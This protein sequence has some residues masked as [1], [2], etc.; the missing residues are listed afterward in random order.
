MIAATRSIVSCLILALCLLAAL[1]G[2]A[3][4]QSPE[5][6]AHRD[7]SALHFY[8]ITVDVGG[9]VWDNF[10]HSALRVVDELND[11]DVVYNWGV[12]E[13]SGGPA[14]LRHGFF[15]KPGGL[16]SCYPEHVPRA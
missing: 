2:V 14:D 7:P 1:T 10:G 12:F 15:L 16:P 6:S 3:Q 8:L 13:V 11:T 9:N 5:S 4:A